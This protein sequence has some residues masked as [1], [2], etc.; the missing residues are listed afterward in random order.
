VRAALRR[1]LRSVDLCW[2][3]LWG[4]VA[5]GS[6]PASE[7]ADLDLPPPVP[8]YPEHTSSLRLSIDRTQA[9]QCH[10]TLVAP[11]WAITAAHCFS[12]VSPDGRGRLREF[13]RG[14]ATSD[15]QFHPLAHASGATRLD[16]VWQNEDFSAAH[17]LALIPLEPLERRSA[18]AL[19]SD[20]PD[21][22]GLDLRELATNL[23]RMTLDGRPE[24]VTG[25]VLG[26]RTAS[27]L[28]GPGQQ[29]D[30]LAVRSAGALPGDSGSGVTVRA[31]DLA[32]AATDCLLGDP[33][34]P[35]VLVGVLQDA[36]PINPR[37]PLGVTPLYLPEHAT[38][39]AQTL[40]DWT[41]APSTD[42]PPVL[43]EPCLDPYGCD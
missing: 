37:A 33:S 19:W 36:N 17:D 32:P 24:T 2:L 1:Q 8:G 18:R 13:D 7:A 35:D 40:R 15:V 28:L 5:C 30:L 16:G 22:A 20:A 6:S 10:A 21:C 23:G 14:F 27:S 12:G 31:S 39:L 26:A 9:K 3:A 34:A 4:T 25:V 41:P 43:E 11:Q 42:E 38:W 29:G